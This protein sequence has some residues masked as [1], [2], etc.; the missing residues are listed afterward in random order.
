MIAVPPALGVSRFAV[1]REFSAA[2]VARNATRFS[3]RG[4]SRRLV[5]L[6]RLAWLAIE[7]RRLLVDLLVESP[8]LISP[9]PPPPRRRARSRDKK[10][11]GGPR[12][13]R[14]G[15]IS[16]ITLFPCYRAVS[17]SPR[18]A[19]RIALVASIIPGPPRC[20]PIGFRRDNDG[21]IRFSLD[22]AAT[23]GNPNSLKDRVVIFG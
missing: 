15:R 19:N 10:R 11:H 14:H 1:S 6:T 21:S 2:N 5:C 16:D 18:S 7:R 17:R 3:P 4:C 9:P 13:I 12:F 22:V 20:R 8:R 23:A